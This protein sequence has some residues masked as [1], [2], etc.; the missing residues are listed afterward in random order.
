MSAI[1][2]IQQRLLSCCRDPIDESNDE[3]LAL[4]DLLIELRQEDRRYLIDVEDET[5]RSP[6]FH[7]IESGK[8]LNFLEEL[9]EFQIRITSRILICAIRYGNFEI[10]KLLQ[11]YGA[12]F[13][14]SYH[15]IS[16]LHECILLHKNNLISFLIEEG[17]VSTI[18]RIHFY[19]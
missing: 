6:L 4:K 14:Q 9:L 16:L 3:L 5:H 19:K 2:A 1:S 15:G 11:K 17:G 12:D 8:S 10:L 7:A 18:E 13:R